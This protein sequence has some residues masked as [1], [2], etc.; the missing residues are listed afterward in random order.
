[1]RCDGQ[2]NPAL[3]GNAARFIGSRNFA[4]MLP[5]YSTDQGTETAVY[6]NFTRRE[7]PYLRQGRDMS[8]GP[9]TPLCDEPTS[10]AG[11]IPVSSVGIIRPRIFI[12]SDVRLYREGLAWSVSQRPELEVIGASAPSAEALAQIASSVPTAVL[13]DFATPG[14]LDL[15]KELSRLLPGIKIIAFA[16]SEIDDELIACAE[17]GIAGFVTRDGSVDDLVMSILNALRGEV[18]CSPHITGLL[19]KH[20]AALSDARSGPSSKHALTR[21]ERE[22]AELV[23][24]G[25]SNKEIA[26]SLRIGSA[27]VKNHVHNILEK[28]HVNRR[29]EAAARLRGELLVRRSDQSCRKTGREEVSVVRR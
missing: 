26:R 16:V 14:A 5:D 24:E 28:L 19:F 25:L 4:A 8:R 21:R 1:M 9:D 29:G 2:A 22:V 10:A 6:F 18:F 20:V 12:L 3:E 17:A 7:G 23:N 13:L 15:P 11:N 27:T